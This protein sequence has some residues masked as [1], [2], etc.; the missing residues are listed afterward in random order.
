MTQKKKLTLFVAAALVLTGTLAT[1]SHTTE[2][3]SIG[4]DVTVHE[5]PDIDNHG[6]VGG[7]RAYSV[8]TTSCNIGD[9]PLWWCDNDRSYC[10]EDQHPVIAQNLYRLKDGRFE[11][12]GMSWLKHGF[13][14]LAN[15]DPECGDGSCD[16]PPHGGDQL[17]V[18]CTDPYSAF[19][20]GLRPL[21]LRSEVNATTGEFPFPE[22]VVPSPLTIDQRI[23]VEEVD[24]DPV[25]NPGALYWIEGQYVA[26]DDA[27]AGNGLNNAS[28]REVTVSGGA[29]NLDLT[30]PTVRKVPAIHA[31]QAVDE[32]VEMVNVDVDSVP[33]QRFHIAR[34]VTEI[35][36]GGWHYEYAVHNLNS[37]RSGRSLTIRFPGAATISEVG[38]RDVD[39]HSGEPYDTMDW[40][41]ATGADSVTWFTELFADDELA[42]ALRWGTMFSFWF[43]AE[44]PP[45]ELLHTLELFKDGVPTTVD[46]FFG[47]E[48]PVQ[49]LIFTDGFESGDTSAWLVPR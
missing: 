32:A 5:L 24:L 33:V 11:Q 46:F 34:R 26:P 27:T 40:A 6:A 37:D 36:A 7:I 38:F 3:G 43:D 13:L 4:P 18:G 39:H 28:Y 31:W 8:A 25:L 22:T 45:A 21:G 42:N 12:L 1:W 48:P 15:S 9:E 14:A 20:N 19:L 29:F 16:P 2:A 23:Q 41:V 30:G 10:E 49:G 35:P 44:L 47:T 17:G